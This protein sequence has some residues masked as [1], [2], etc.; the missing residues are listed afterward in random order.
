MEKVK[1][2]IVLTIIV[3][4]LIV[5]GIAVFLLNSAGVQRSLKDIQSNYTGGLKRTVEVLDY[6]GN[7]IRTYSGKIDIEEKTNNEI[8][9]ELDGKRYIIY[10]CP[11]IVEEK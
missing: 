11:V 7:V 9:F 4:S 8:K 6:S 1:T 5:I 3:A 10:N 2:K